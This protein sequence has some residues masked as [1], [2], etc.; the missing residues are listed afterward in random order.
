MA[1]ILCVK[2][3]QNNITYI[4]IYGRLFWYCKKIELR[5]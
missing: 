5:N 1:V 4:F 3:I 2:K